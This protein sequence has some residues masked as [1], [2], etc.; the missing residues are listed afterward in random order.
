ME[1]KIYSLMNGKKGGKNSM[2]KDRKKWEKM[3]TFGDLRIIK[4]I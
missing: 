2:K 4:I 1:Q 3:V